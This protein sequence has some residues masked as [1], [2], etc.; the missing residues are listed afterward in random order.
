MNLIRSKFLVSVSYSRISVV[1]VAEEYNKTFAKQC[2]FE[3]EGGGK[4]KIQRPFLSLHLYSQVAQ[5]H[6]GNK[7]A[8]FPPPPP[9]PFPL[10]MRLAADR[11]RK[12]LLSQINLTAPRELSHKLVTGVLNIAPTT[13]FTL[14]YRIAI[15]FSPNKS[16]TSLPVNG[17]LYI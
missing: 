6:R 9:P 1:Q 17:N 4:I 12:A 16:V 8:L 10:S 5:R 3:G 2:S 14:C 15:N 11:R 13:V 7:L